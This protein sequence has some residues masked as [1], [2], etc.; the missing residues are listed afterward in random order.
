MADVFISYAHRNRERV[1]S[2][3]D[4]LSSEGYSL[5]WDPHMRAGDVFAS[6]IE[7]ELHAARCVVVAWSSVA[8]DSLWV[9]AEATEALEAGKLVQVVLDRVKP[10][11]P[12]TMVHFADLSRWNGDG[13]SPEWCQLQSG[14]RAVTREGVSTRVQESRESRPVA[15]VLGPVIAVGGGSVGLVALTSALTGMATSGAF[16]QGTFGAVVTAGFVLACLAL[17]HMCTRVI[18]VALASRRS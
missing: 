18:Q 11:I 6:Q 15:T 13:A 17:G 10:P 3:A 9:R 1:A 5:W 8:R 12:F 7:H 16:H 4:R 14:V 2:I